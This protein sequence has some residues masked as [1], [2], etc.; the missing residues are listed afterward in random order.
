MDPNNNNFNQN[1]NNRN[2]TPIEPTQPVKNKF[3]NFDFDKN[4]NNVGGTV[5]DT[6]H[7]VISWGVGKKASEGNQNFPTFNNSQAASQEYNNHSLMSQVNSD[8]YNGNSLETLEDFF[9]ASNMQQSNAE[10]SKGFYP[11]TSNF[12]NSNP[13]FYSSSNNNIIP[14]L[15]TNTENSN[16]NNG[17]GYTMNYNATLNSDMLNKDSF[18]NKPANNLNNNASSNRFFDNG[19]MNGDGNTQMT[20]NQNNSNN[21][22]NFFNQSNGNNNMSNTGE[23]LESELPKLNEEYLNSMASNP[24]RTNFNNQENNI[25]NQAYPQNQAN[26]QNFQNLGKNSNTL[27][28]ELPNSQNN[29]SYPSNTI[30]N[31]YNNMQNPPANTSQQFASP[32]FAETHNA[33]QQSFLNTPSSPSAQSQNYNQGVVNPGWQDGIGTVNPQG[34]TWMN[35]QP[36]SAASLGGVS[37]NMEDAPKD[38]IQESRFFNANI[39]NEKKSEQPINPGY[40]YGNGVGVVLEDPAPVYNELDFLKQY[41]N[42]D[43]THLNMQIFSF[44][45][46]LFGSLS[47]LSRKIYTLGIILT[48]IEA[49]LV[50]FLPLSIAAISLFILHII[51]ALSINPIYKK[52]AKK[53]VKKILDNKDNQKKNIVEL[54]NICRKKGKKNIPLAIM[55]YILCCGS[56]Y[57]FTL[58]T[59]LTDYIS[60]IKNKINDAVESSKDKKEEEEKEETTEKKFNIEDYL[61]ITIPSTFVR[62]NTEEYLYTYVTDTNTPN[63]SCELSIRKL[64][65]INSVEEYLK[66][67]KN[68]ENI[69]ENVGMTTSNNITWYTL[70]DRK[71]GQKKYYRATAI[72][73]IPILL[74]Y[75][76]GSETKED[77]CEKN[78]TSIIG[79]IRLK[80]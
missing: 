14:P 79:S 50:V 3:F 75:S 28:P 10:A 74:E 62:S 18:P 23:I 20:L 38:V 59:N 19:L 1:F 46:L 30:E 54:N 25:G 77:I 29:L 33:N 66:E 9:P 72:D 32:I 57:A 71:D 76:I 16:Y 65:K 42:E 61:S 35:N 40:V 63:N 17:L 56:V 22:A 27:S 26:Y 80:E 15:E 60:N 43:L 52:H 24:S 44:R 11:N 73:T 51:L 53:K 45:T 69:I 58:T 49:S 2:T 34:E 39:N 31:Q 21:A 41:I 37:T 68:K 78:Y 4:E 6:S 67:L 12:N 8:V 36:L 64:D 7:N 48:I 70:G 13:S 47:F 5:S 55:I